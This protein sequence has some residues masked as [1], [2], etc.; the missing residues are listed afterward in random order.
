MTENQ[1]T[2]PV[3][4]LNAGV[5]FLLLAVLPFAIQSLLLLVRI[6][7]NPVVF[8]LCFI[9]AAGNMLYQSK[10]FGLTIKSS[11]GWLL[12]VLLLA[13]GAHLAAVSVYDFSYDGMWYHQDAVILL[14]EG[15]NPNTHYLQLNET[16]FSDLYLNHYPKAT[17]ISQATYYCVFPGQLESGKVLN[18][19]LLFAAFFMSLAVIRRLLGKGWFISVVFALLI[20][21]NPVVV[22]QLFS[23]YVDGAIGSLLTCVVCL[24]LLLLAEKGNKAHLHIYLALAFAFLVNIKFTSLIYACVLMVGYV[25][26]SFF[27]RVAWLKQTIFYAGVF[28]LGVLVLGYSTYVRNTVQ[29]GHPFYPLMGKDNIGEKVAQVIMPANFLDKNR[30]EK[31]N[32]ATF[33]KPVWSRSPL[34]SRPKPLFTMEGMTDYD[35]FKRADAEMSGFGPTYAE[36]LLMV[37][38]GLIILL[39][40]DR[41][42]LAFHH[43][44]LYGTLIVSIVIMPEFWY[45]RYAPQLWLLTMLLVMALFL[46]RKTQWLAIIIMLFTVANIQM[47]MKQNFSKFIE[48]TSTLNKTFDML[49]SYL[50]PPQVSDG[51]VRSVKVKMKEE[52]LTYTPVSAYYPQDSVI[53][54]PG[55]EMSNAFYVP[56]K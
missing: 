45:A 12:L 3:A 24:M 52:G 50:Q 7:L 32:L 18:F 10:R 39:L 4:I 8:P 16:S 21:L 15:W 40:F 49:K 56:E 42:T 53:L 26:Y 22:C 11:I 47:V 30:F 23:F 9:L 35:V 29:N 5:F 13:M 19:Y 25:V 43:L 20:A 37:A 44:I 6:P 36:I 33:A 28:V 46:S 14:K 31:F 38:G 2:T 51:W 1:P 55:I 54:F 41:K 27:F 48:Q 34:N 17:W